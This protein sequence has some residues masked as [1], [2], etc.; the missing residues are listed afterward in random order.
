MV[1]PAAGVIVLKD[2]WRAP[3][4]QQVVHLVL[5]PPSQRLAQDLPCFIHVKVSRPQETQDVLVFRN[6]NGNN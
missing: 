1:V 2:L 3:G 4:F 6:L 5:L